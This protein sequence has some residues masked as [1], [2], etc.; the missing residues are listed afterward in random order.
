MEKAPAHGLST[1]RI[2]QGTFQLSVMIMIFEPASSHLDSICLGAGLCLCQPSFE[3][4]ILADDIS[5][6]KVIIPVLQFGFGA[7]MSIPWFEINVCLVLVLSLDQEEF[8]R[9][10]AP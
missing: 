9:P 5:F 10:R 4:L 2:Y 7:V 8:A 1:L 3:A 6:K